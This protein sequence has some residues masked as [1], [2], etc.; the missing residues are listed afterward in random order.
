[1]SEATIANLLAMMPRQQTLQL[2]YLTLTPLEKM[3][4]AV[5]I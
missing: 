4:I 2:K 5:F 3:A 1:M